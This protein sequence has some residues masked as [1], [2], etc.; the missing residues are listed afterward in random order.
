MVTAA[1]VFSFHYY[2]I[3]PYQLNPHY[4]PPETCSDS[5]PNI[6]LYVLGRILIGEIKLLYLVTMAYIYD[7]AQI[8]RQYL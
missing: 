6:F 1:Y 8:P 2:S 3:D 7:G 5:S 4:T